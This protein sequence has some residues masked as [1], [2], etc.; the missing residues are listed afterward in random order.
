MVFRSDVE[1]AALH[2]VLFATGAAVLRVPEVGL[3]HALWGFVLVYNVAVPLYFAVR[4]IESA[5]AIWTFLV[6][7]SL[8]QIGP[9][10]F[11]A[12]E[13][14]TLAFPTA[15]ERTVVP[16]YMGGLWVP[17]LLL[18]T[19][20][21]ERIAETRG[22]RGGLFAAAAAGLVLFAA[23]ETLLTAAG[24][25]RAVGVYELGGAAAYILGPEALL[26]AA[27]FY[28]YRGTRWTGLGVRIGGAALVSCL[29]LGA[30]CASFLVVERGIVPLL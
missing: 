7:L 15:G 5:V 8:F 27:A 23:S 29:Y 24:V 30:A 2:A 6:P 12:G 28:A 20:L 4:E 26:C 13:L 19:Y 22:V 16:A 3:T 9:D 11:L 14:G 10:W 1:V 21:G 18:T 25:W 17:P